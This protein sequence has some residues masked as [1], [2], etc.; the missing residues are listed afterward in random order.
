MTKTNAGL[1]L[2]WN[3]AIGIAAGY[4][5]AAATATSGTTL[6]ATGTPWGV[7]AFQGMVVV[8]GNVYGAILSNTSSVL[9]I[10]RWYN[11][12]TPGGAAGATPSATVVFTI[13]PQAPPSQFMGIT[14][15]ATAVAT[16][17]TVLPG[18]ITTAGGGLI[19]KQGTL[20]HTAGAA[21]GTVVG[22][23]TGNG[24]DTYPV[25]IAKMGIGPS[26]LSTAN[27]L[28]QTVLNATA[29]L[30]ASGDQVTITDTITA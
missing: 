6:T 23:F 17:D 24:S 19:R 26:L 25:V 27:Q 1:D 15:N 22:V 30:N 12:A 29:T 16:G 21:T 11:P 18:E 8:A 5:A 13:M 28:F 14:A 3:E 7:N 9:T 4:S 10:D 2:E 20:A